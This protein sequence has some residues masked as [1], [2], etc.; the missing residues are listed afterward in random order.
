MATLNLPNS[1]V[2]TTIANA[3]EVNA[4]FTAVKNFVETNVVQTDGSVRAGT[5]AINDSAVTTAKI[6]DS[7]VTTAKI[8]DSAVTLVKLGTDVPRFTVSTADPTG[9]SNGDVWVKVLP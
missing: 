8:A 3:N 4:N 6:A 9:G 1:F 7:N 2:N 5:P